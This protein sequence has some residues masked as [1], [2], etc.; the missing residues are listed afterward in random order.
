MVGHIYILKS[1]KNGKYYVGS[2]DNLE[3]R[4]FEHNSGCDKSKFT[5]D[6]RP[7]ELVFSQEYKNLEIAR[8]IEYRLKSFKSRKILEEIVKDGVCNLT[9]D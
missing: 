2:T 9:I 7:F 3:R 1:L 6:N 4:F 5:R 8:K